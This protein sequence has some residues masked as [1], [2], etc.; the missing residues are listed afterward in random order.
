[1]ACP[2]QL[3]PDGFEAAEIIQAL[4]LQPRPAQNIEPI[5]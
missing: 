5:P 4:D 3:R 1:L 2:I